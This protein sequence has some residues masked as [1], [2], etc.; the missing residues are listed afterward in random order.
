MHTCYW[1]SNDPKALVKFQMVGIGSEVVLQ[2][3]VCLNCRA[4]NFSYWYFIS[5]LKFFLLMIWERQCKRVF[6]WKFWTKAWT[7]LFSHLLHFSF[8]LP[9]ISFWIATVP[10][11]CCDD[12]E[13]KGTQRCLPPV[14]VSRD[15]SG[16]QSYSR[17][18]ES[19]MV[20][21]WGAL[22]HTAWTDQPLTH[23]LKWCRSYPIRRDV[24]CFLTPC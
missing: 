9:I 1:G 13:V 4:G 10:S 6:Y 7:F 24:L 11:L 19:E 5:I 12:A 23:W 3:K 20:Q 15:N 16:M 18:L 2:S 21:W 22:D 8:F 14:A 17:C